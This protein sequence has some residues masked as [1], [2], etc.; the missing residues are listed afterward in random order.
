MTARRTLKF[1]T[2]TQ[3]ISRVGDD[4]GELERKWPNGAVASDGA[5]YCLPATTYQVLRI[6]P[7]QEEF[8]TK[9]KADMEEHPKVLGFL[10]DTKLRCKMVIILLF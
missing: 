8:A 4:F 5:V 9:L 2:E 7:F 6:D 10:F 1:D 3:T